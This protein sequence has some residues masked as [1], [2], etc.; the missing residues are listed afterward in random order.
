MKTFFQ[1]LAAIVLCQLAG[2]IGSFF[3]VTEISSWY[4]T[5]EKPALNPPNWVFGPVWT[6]LYTMMG[7]ALFLVWKQFDTS[8]SARYAVFFFL[9][10]LVVN[11]AWT[12][13]FFGAKEVALAL[14]VIAILWLMIAALIGWF[15]KIDRVAALLL[16][17]YLLWVSFASYLNFAILQLNY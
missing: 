14:I 16:V 9:V 6:L 8:K 1:I 7:I 11:T 3:T 13:V 15:W 2:V 10:H 17:P 12:L 5:L 4:T